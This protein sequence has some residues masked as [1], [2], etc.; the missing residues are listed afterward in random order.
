MVRGPSRP[1][2]GEGRMPQTRKLRLTSVAAMTMAA[3]LGTACSM[4]AGGGGGGGSGSTTLTVAAVDNP[5]MV[6]LQKLAPEFTKQ[7]PNIQ[8]KFV[9]L[10][11]NQL[12]QQ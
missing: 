11:E 1:K 7:H 10:P 9:V 2:L 3:L 4:G 12:R 6:D 5:Q 8:V